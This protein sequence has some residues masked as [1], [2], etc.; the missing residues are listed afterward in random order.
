[1][2]QQHWKRIINGKNKIAIGIVALELLV[3]LVLLAGLFQK[4][5]LIQLT[6]AQQTLL[7][8]VYHPESDLCTIDAC[9]GYTGIFTQVDNLALKKGVYK[10][11]IDFF[12]EGSNLFE[13]KD[14]NLFYGSFLANPVTLYP[15]DTNAEF[16]LWLLEDTN[17]MSLTTTYSGTGSFSTGLIQIKEDNLYKTG[18]FLFCLIFFSFADLLIFSKKITG[19]FLQ[20]KEQKVAFFALGGIILTASL[21]LMLDNVYNS[22]YIL[23]QLLRTDGIKDALLSGQFPVRVYPNILNEYGYAGAITGSD[24]FLYFPALLHLLG[25]PLQTAWKFF[26]FL[27]NVATAVIAYISFGKIARR[28]YVGILGSML[29]TLSAY[30]LDSV[31]FKVDVQESLWIMFLPFLAYC[32]YRLFTEDH[33]TKKYERIWIPFTLAVSGILLSS[34]SACIMTGVFVLLLFIFRLSKIFRKTTFFVLTKT[35]VATLLL[36]LWFLV[37]AADY[38]LFTNA[39]F[40]KRADVRIQS[41][42]IEIS[43]IFGLLFQGE[44]TVNF[45]TNTMNILEYLGWGMMIGVLVFLG[46]AISKKTPNRSKKLPTGIAALLMSALALFMSTTI[47]PWDKISNTKDVFAILISLITSPYS[48]LCVVILGFTLAVCVGAEWILQKNKEIMNWVFFSSIAVITLLTTNYLLNEAM[49][50][51]G[52]F[53]IYDGNTLISTLLLHDDSLP[54]GT[55][56]NGLFY[57]ELTVPEGLLITDYKKDELSVRFFCENISNDSI[58]LEVP[59]LYFKGYHAVD[60]EMKDTLQLIA[61]TN[62]VLQIQIPYGYIGTLEVSFEDLWYWKVANFISLLTMVVLAFILSERVKNRILVNMKT[63]QTGVEN[64]L[65]NE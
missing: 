17:T 45:S 35:G 65:E 30:R 25:L 39:A 59:L 14:E 38:A 10:I 52:F 28:R 1:M 41:A 27:L 2:I 4:G 12:S 18:R 11:S 56:L 48:F 5:T 62:N 37:P 15:G 46:L 43:R 42:G 40:M 32:L 54:G 61:G 23:Q 3:L 36:N 51:R 8:G 29:Y 50:N 53:R 7:G 60:L 49:L 20:K 24:L 44:D 9:S 31:Y 58:S 6:G 22:G 19:H 13:A 16:T 47:F 33:T 34:F 21:P 57:Q 63:R 55:D 64:E 26:M